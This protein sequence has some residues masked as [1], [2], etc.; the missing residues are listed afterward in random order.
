MKKLR[1]TTPASTSRKAK[2]AFIIFTALVLMGTGMSYFQAK[3]V[4]ADQY[5]DKIRALQSEM[6]RYQTEANR[7]NSEAVTLGNALA[8]LTN[9]KN[10]LQTQVDVSQAQHD[11]LVIQISDTEKEIKNNQDALGTC[12]RK[13]KMM[14]R[15]TRVLSKIALH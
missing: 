1:T 9:E 13:L 2:N 14:S 15:A 8:Q 10:A 11:K 5:D 6:S 3:P 4:S 7:L 12:Y